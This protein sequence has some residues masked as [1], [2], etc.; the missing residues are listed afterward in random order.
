M[1]TELKSFLEDM[2]AHLQNEIQKINERLTEFESN[3]SARF[4][5]LEPRF[6][7]LQT[8]VNGIDRRITELNEDL[9]LVIQQTSAETGLLRFELAKIKYG[10]HQSIENKPSI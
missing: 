1:D 6:N 7:H 5:T 9:R 10:Q 2:Q 8:Q 3:V 4:D